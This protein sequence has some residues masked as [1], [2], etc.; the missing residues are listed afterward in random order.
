MTLE[1]VEGHPETGTEVGLL[2]ND[3]AAIAQWIASYDTLP[4]LRMSAS[5]EAEWPTARS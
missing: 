3:P 2:G 1:P 4:P 5:E